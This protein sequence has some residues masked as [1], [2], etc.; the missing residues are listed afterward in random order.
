M[1]KSLVMTRIVAVGLLTGLACALVPAAR[2]AGGTRLF[3]IDCGVSP[4]F[5]IEEPG[6]Y[7]LRHSV[8]E[9]PIDLAIVV[10]ASDVT[11]DLGGRTIG[12]THVGIGIETS[13]ETRRVSIVNG[14]VRDF[15]RGIQ[16]LG[17]QSEVNG[18]VLTSHAEEGIFTRAENTV[19]NST[20]SRNGE[21]GIQA[22]TG[23]TLIRNISTGNGEGGFGVGTGNDLIRNTAT[24]NADHG[25]SA[26]T[27]NTFTRNT[28][29][30]NGRN[31]ISV[32][33][34]NTLRKNLSTGNGETGIAFGTD[35]TLTGNIVKG[36]AESGIAGGTGN[37]LSKNSSVG[38]GEHGIEVGLGNEV[39]RNRA[40]ANVIDGIHISS[41]DDATT[42]SKNVTN[43]NGRFG[44]NTLGVVTPGAGTNKAKRNGGSTQC[45]PVAMCR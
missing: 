45:N 23:N 3:T 13:P 21:D 31:G 28:V 20:A 6:T 43:D 17:E 41:A 10:S 15:E 27:G 30:G 11:V 19:A 34:G 9:C 35:N 37:T 4:G 7:L 12:G 26:G 14:T 32:G 18:V 42:A 44:L 29:T 8:R 24:G 16:L 5:H 22:G 33:T 36:N 38:N 1:R 39:V 40:H 2:S 25:I